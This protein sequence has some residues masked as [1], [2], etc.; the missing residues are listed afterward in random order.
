[1]RTIL[2]PA[3]NKGS[4]RRRPGAGEFG[5]TAPAPGRDVSGWQSPVQSDR[6]PRVKNSQS[7]IE[8]S[9]L[10]CHTQKMRTTLKPALDKGSGRRRPGAGAMFPFSPAPRGNVSGWSPPPPVSTAKL[11][12]RNG[13]RFMHDCRNP[14]RTKIS[15]TA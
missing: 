5:N 2:K 3:L 8:N 10:K 4:G 11:L 6:P 15:I 13:F 7:A 12:I 9:S 14:L 1:M